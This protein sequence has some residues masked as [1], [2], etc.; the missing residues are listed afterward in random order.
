MFEP[1]RILVPTD[2]TADSDRALREAIDLAAASRGKVY[3]LHV[4]EKIPLVVGEALLDPDVVAAAEKSDERLSRQQMAE[5][6]RRVASGSDVE[7]EID[8]R[9]G[10]TFEEIARYTRDKLIDLVVIGPH[11][12]KGLLKG[13]QASVTG[14]LLKEAPCPMLVLPSEA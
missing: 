7:I 1:K 10:G 13:L 6:V 8:E 4:D 11:A 14:R 2:F 9:R 3:L 5:E 12:R